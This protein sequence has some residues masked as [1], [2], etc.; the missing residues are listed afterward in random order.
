[1][2]DRRIDYVLLGRP[3]RGGAAH[4]VRCALAGTEPVAGVVPS[5]HYAVFADLRY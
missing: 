2:P 3:R 1:L 5:D 4:V